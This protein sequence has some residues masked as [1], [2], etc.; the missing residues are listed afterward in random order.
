LLNNWQCN[1]QQEYYAMAQRNLSPS[2]AKRQAEDAAQQASPWIKQLGRFGYAAKGIVYALVGVLAVQAALGRGGQTTDTQGALATLAQS[3]FEKVLLAL[4]AIGL[5]GYA[6]WKLVQA[7]LDTENK[8]SDAKGMAV[9]AAYAGIGVIHLGLAL[10]AARLLLAGGGN[11]SSEQSTQDW[12]ARLMSQPRGQWLVALVGA[13]VIGFGLYQF[14]QAYKAK[15]RED[16]KLAEMSATEETWATRMGRLGYAA[17]GVVF[18]IIGGFLIVAAIQAQ[19]QEARG[20]G[21]ALET[22]AQ[23]PYGPWLLGIVAL[24]LVAYGMF[25]LVEARYRRMVLTS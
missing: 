20:L 25:M 7:L 19:P 4:I 13:V 24:G 11:Q 8:E 2:H 3:P 15:F 23:Q 9:R 17:R 10:A 22:L 18:S 21:G 14:Y 5:M 6:V 1:Q 12:T 16:L